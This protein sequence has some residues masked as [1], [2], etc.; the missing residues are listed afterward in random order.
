MCVC[1]C[2]PSVLQLSTVYMC[3]LNVSKLV[4]L[5]SSCFRIAKCRS[6]ELKH[7]REWLVLSPGVEPSSQASKQAPSWLHNFEISCDSEKAHPSTWVT[8]PLVEVY[9]QR[10]MGEACERQTLSCFL[11]KAFHSGGQCESSRNS[12][13]LVPH[14]CSRGAVSSVFICGELL[15]FLS[16]PHLG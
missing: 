16:S 15:A 13:T 3:L 5:G 9:V 4:P 12:F 14:A 2:V 7:F 1:G 8:D 10:S 6:K 11:L